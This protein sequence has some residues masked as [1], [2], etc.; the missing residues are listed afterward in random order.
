MQLIKG[1]VQ[2][3]KAYHVE[4]ID[5]EIKLHA[6]E[7]PFPPP[8]EIL[9]LF[10]DV[11]KTSDLNRYP[12]PDCRLLKQTLSKRLGVIPE[13]LAIGNGSDELIQILLQVFCDLGDTV[14]FPDPT[15]AM[16]A[17]IAQGM[18]LKSLTHPLDDQWDFKAEPFLES[19][20][21]SGARI[22]FLSYPNNPTGNCFS[23]SEVQKV[24]ENFS[25]IVVVDEAYH[26]FAR[27]T[28]LSE[29]PRHNNLIILRSMSKIGLAALRVGYAVADPAIIAQINKIRLPYNLNT[30]SQNLTDRLL[31]H[32]APVQQQIDTLLAE[33]SRMIDALSKFGQ[34]TVYPSDANFV[35]FRVEQDSAAL[36]KR[37]MDKDTLIRDLGSHPRLKNCLRVTIGTPAENKSFL[38]QMAHIIK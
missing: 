4:N 10:E 37:L 35:L 8:P 7:N 22:A 38:E 9:K 24:I 5:C 36:Y 34:L 2:S 12:D 3:L 26:D 23:G 17:I 21:A 14:G 1:R 32:F 6:N 33:R 27:K 31:N 15:F 11:F 18:G 20:E 13:N 28:F 29:L 19:L 25:G 16:Y 30:V